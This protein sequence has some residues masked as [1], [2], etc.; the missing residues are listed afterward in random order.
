MEIKELNLSLV[1]RQST[2]KLIIPDE[3]EK[4]IRHLCNRIHD[5]EWSGTLF[6]TYE[7][8]METNDLVITC[9]DIFVMDIGTS[10]YTE[11]DMSP[12]VISYMTDNPELLDMQMGLIHSH[13]NMG[14]FFSGTD[15]NTLKEEGKDR[16]H[17]VSLIV[18]NAGTY[19]A[20]ITRKV[21]TVKVIEELYNYDSFNDKHESDTVKYT[22][23]EEC[24]EYFS[25][26]IIKEGTQYSFNSLDKRLEEIRK[27]KAAVKIINTSGVKEDF[28]KPYPQIISTSDDKPKFIPSLFNDVNEDDVQHVLIQLLTGS[29]IIR[30]PSKIDIDRWAAS[31]P[32]VFGKRFNSDLKAFESWAEQFCEFLIFDKEKPMNNA[33]EEAQWLSDFSQAL[34]Y[35]LDSLPVNRYVDILK[36]ITEQWITE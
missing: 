23:E 18:N 13:N 7:G 3:V 14:T 16:N 6:Y 24:I 19:T 32:S 5:V 2:Y 27:R 10:G 28:T 4:K 12:E 11:F 34:Y 22:Q 29:V 30:D 33:D 36:K 8:S 21:R 20:A 15:L 25:L 9:R 17:F 26:D 31:M 1:K 35:E